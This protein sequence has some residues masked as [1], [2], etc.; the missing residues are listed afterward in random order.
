M[1]FEPTSFDAI[2]VNPQPDPSSRTFLLE[3]SEEF[4]KILVFEL[5]Y[6]L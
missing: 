4:D 5:N 6:Y 1:V 2:P 3:N